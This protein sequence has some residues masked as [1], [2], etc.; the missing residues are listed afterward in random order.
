M[1]NE[2]ARK[3][4]AR[5]LDDGVAA[6][7]LARLHGVVV[8]QRGEPVFER[9]WT[10]EDEAWGR[11]L[12]RVAYGPDKLHDLRSVTKSIVGLLYGI[13]LDDG[14][15]PPPETRLLDAFPG[16]EHLAN[17]RRRQRETLEHVLTMTMGNRW[18]EGLDYTDP[19]NAE[20]Q[21]E[22][23]SDR[24][25]FVLEQPMEREAG[26]LWHYSGGATALLAALIVRGSGRTLSAFCLER[27]LSP[28]GIESFEW[29]KGP[30]LGDDV[31]ASGLRLR[32]PDL[33]RIGA[34][35]LRGGR[36]N[37]GQVVP[38]SWIE[39]SMVARTSLPGDE[40]GYG[41][42]WYLLPTRGPAR[43]HAANG[44][45]GQKLSLHRD[46]EIVIA[47]NAGRYND[48]EA[49]R[50]PYAVAVDHVFPTLFG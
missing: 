47:I 24:V 14:L 25:R 37:G 12:G 42:Q 6:G 23:S 46:G 19:G 17:D 4:L 9:Y 44:N 48:P 21:M 18:T 20:V 8:L 7:A 5:R 31:P 28:L 36:A 38:A 32:L 43:F 22:Q 50:L 30:M 3:D 45:G 1:A 49:W 2:A 33:A 29:V 15:V 39:R 26:Q 41:Y 16:F 27:L 35:V 34:M 13:A 10:D 11:P 40:L